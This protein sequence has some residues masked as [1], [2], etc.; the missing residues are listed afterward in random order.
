MAK[1]R[2]EYEVVELREGMIGGKMSGDELEKGSTRPPQPA[3]S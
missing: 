3:G 1:Q 2:F